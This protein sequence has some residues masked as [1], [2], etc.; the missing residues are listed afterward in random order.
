VR[1]ALTSGGPFVVD[2]DIDA[3][4]P[5]YRSAP[6]KYPSDFGERGLA[7]PPF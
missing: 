2:V 7:R 4:A 6:Y 1:R 5:G 3:E